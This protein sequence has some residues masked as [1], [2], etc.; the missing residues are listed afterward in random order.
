M[1]AY[2]IIMFLVG[3]IV[4][5]LGVK[6]F[7]GRTG[8]IDSHHQSKVTD[9]ARYGRAFGGSVILISL[10]IFVSGIVAFFAPSAAL[11]VL[12]VGLAAGIGCIAAV[13]I[14]YNKGIF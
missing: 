10:A 11:A 4:F 9:R 13:Q 8:L 12:L 5:A 2:S 1:T 14:K 3:A 6:V 7:R